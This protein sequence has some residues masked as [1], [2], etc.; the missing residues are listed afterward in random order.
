MPPLV[1]GGRAQKRSAEERLLNDLGSHTEHKVCVY[2]CEGQVE[3]KGEIKSH[4]SFNEGKKQRKCP[5][6][7]QKATPPEINSTGH[8]C[9]Q[10]FRKGYLM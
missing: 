9:S 1:S 5:L 10:E 8:K 2:V 7:T 3:V 6:G 4:F